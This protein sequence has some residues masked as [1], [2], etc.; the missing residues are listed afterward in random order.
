M[1][2]ADPQ[3]EPDQET[4]AKV[5]VFYCHNLTLRHRGEPDGVVWKIRQGG[6]GHEDQE[7][8]LRP[9][10]EAGPGKYSPLIG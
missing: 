6:Q 5:K 4:M 9:L 1:D 2:W 7:L 3:K 8:R 10:R